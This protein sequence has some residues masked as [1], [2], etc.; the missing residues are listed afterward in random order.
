MGGLCTPGKVSTDYLAYAPK[1]P[2]AFELASVLALGGFFGSGT[3]DILVR[4]GGQVGR[5]GTSDAKETYA[6]KDQRVHDYM[7]AKFFE[8]EAR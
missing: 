6:E 3:G 1:G 5:C 2:S 4:F 8:A 7:D